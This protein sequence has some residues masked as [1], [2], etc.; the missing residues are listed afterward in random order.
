[1]PAFTPLPRTFYR[2]PTLLSA[3]AL[4]GAFV[5]RRFEDG[6]IA[7]CRI[8][9]T[10]AYTVGDPACHAFRGKSVANAAMFGAPGTAYVHI[11]YGLHYCLNAVTAEEGV[12]EAVLIRAIEPVIG[13][14]RMRANYTGSPQVPDAEAAT[15]KRIGAGPGRLTRA[16]AITKPA[17]NGHDLTDGDS[18]LFLAAGEPVADDAVTVAA[19]IGIT[20]GADLPW[21]W[22]VTASRFVS[23]R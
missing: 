2:Q 5:V 8:V 15:D 23:R 13:A 14:G 6:M 10:E 3:R 22:Y 11:N 9:E 7:G 19:R 4:L 21:R 18:A 17:F 20:K 1:M 12:P 16:L